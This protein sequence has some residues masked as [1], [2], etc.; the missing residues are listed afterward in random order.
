MGTAGKIGSVVGTALIFS[1]LSNLTRK[2]E[3]LL[4]GKKKRKKGGKK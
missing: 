3:K 4:K 1:A 2:T